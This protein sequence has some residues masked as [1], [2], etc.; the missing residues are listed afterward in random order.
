MTVHMLLPF[1][2]EQDKGGASNLS[3][4][5]YCSYI[6]TNTS[7]KITIFYITGMTEEYYVASST[8][9]F[10]IEIYL[11]TTDV[12][13]N[14]VATNNYSIVYQS[15]SIAICIVCYLQ[16]GSLY[17]YQNAIHQN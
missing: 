3:H 14:N 10:Y 4:A 1:T 2:V 6:Y 8:D 17:Y 16:L 11:Y 7:P 12:Y 9:N 5:R 13:R 15:L